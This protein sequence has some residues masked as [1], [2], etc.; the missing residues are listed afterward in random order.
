MSRY[1]ILSHLGEGATCKVKL[2]LDQKTGKNVALKLLHGDPT[3][4]EEVMNEMNALQNLQHPN[5]LQMTDHGIDTFKNK[6][7]AYIA[8][9]LANMGTLFDMV[10]ETGP[11]HEDL[12]RYYFR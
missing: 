4:S 7:K 1:E 12:A 8:L 5:I 2:A 10:L 9:E 3:G 11:F 6:Q